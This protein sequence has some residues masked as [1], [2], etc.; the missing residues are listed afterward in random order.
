MSIHVT[1]T[2]RADVKSL[3]DCIDVVARDAHFLA[4]PEAPP[5]E[6]LVSDLRSCAEKGSVPLELYR[7]T[8]FAVEAIVR[9]AMK[10]DGVYH[11]AFRMCL[12]IVPPSSGTHDAATRDTRLAC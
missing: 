11:D 1:P 6:A 7:S 8:G 5:E 12:V 2:H 10:I 9:G 3:R 4:S